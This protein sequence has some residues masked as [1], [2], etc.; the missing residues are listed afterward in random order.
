MAVLRLHA[1]IQM[2]V[3]TSLL[4]FLL[5]AIALAGSS[6]IA[7]EMPKG[8]EKPRESHWRD[9]LAEH[10]RQTEKIGEVKTEVVLKGGR[11]DIETLEYAIEVDRAKKWHEAIGQ[12]LHYSMYLKKKP[13]IAL[14]D[15]D[16]LSPDG[17][18]AMKQLADRNGIEIIFIVLK[19]EETEAIPFYRFTNR[20]E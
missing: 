20:D 5:C 13:C 11:C 10:F 3:F 14:F 7:V 1:Y 4:C 15:L 2:K 12:A 16:T 18:D 8:I 17:L 6:E 9:A 19:N